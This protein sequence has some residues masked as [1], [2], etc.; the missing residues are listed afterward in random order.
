[1]KHLHYRTHTASQNSPLALAKKRLRI[2]EL[3]D[4]LGLEGN[5]ATSCHSPFRVDRSPSFS[6]WDNG[7][8]WHDFAEGT[9]GDA[10]DFLARATNLSKSEAARR[11]IEMAKTSG[12]PPVSITREAK[13]APVRQIRSLP[14]LQPCELQD[15]MKLAHLRRWPLS[16][17]LEIAA[18]RGVLWT[19][20]LRDGSGEPVRCW[21]VTDDR[22]AVMQAR[23]LDGKPFS[24]RWDAASGEWQPCL[25]FKSKTLRGDANGASWP[26]GAANLTA[27]RAVIFCEG[28]PDFLAAFG[29]AFLAGLAEALDVVTILG[30]TNRIA[31]VALPLFAGKRIRFLTQSDDAGRAAVRRW[32]LQLKDAGAGEMDAVFIA[33]DPHPDEDPSAPP[34]RD[35]ADL[36]AAVQT[37]VYPPEVA[38]LFAGLEGGVK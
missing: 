4:R 10:V 22:R 15:A 28:G 29:L 30:A 1:M 21:A 31:T 35:A 23:R 6:V 13:P 5:P 38:P 3:W 27:G 32:A 2:P 19:V 20:T 37:H 16:T 36:L 9:W 17:G 8:R 14:D 12:C 18:G 7:L 33:P 24:H 25:P 11:F 34:I 26:V